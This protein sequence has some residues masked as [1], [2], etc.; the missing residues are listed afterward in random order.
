MIFQAIIAIILHDEINTINKN[1]TTKDPYSPFATQTGF[2]VNHNF[3][4]R[5]KL[6]HNLCG[7]KLYYNYNFCSIQY[8]FFRII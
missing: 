2:R 7:G 4:Q 6:K 1:I 3:I 5:I 8:V